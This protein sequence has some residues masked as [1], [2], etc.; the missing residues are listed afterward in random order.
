MK[1]VKFVAKHP[2]RTRRHEFH[3]M[4][5]SKRPSTQTGAANLGKKEKE[6]VKF[7]AKHPKRT[8]RHEFHEMLFSKTPSTQTGAANLGKQEKELVKLVKFVAKHP[9]RTRAGLPCIATNFTN[10]TNAFF[11][12]AEH[13]NRSCQPWK[14]RKRISE[15]SEIRGKNTLE[16]VIVFPWDN[17]LWSKRWFR[18]ER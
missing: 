8:R 1:L 18:P 13:S 10:F 3:E 16:I 12:K 14:T 9:K 6:L 4:L 2:K 11:Q 17:P 7:V 5:F 15:I